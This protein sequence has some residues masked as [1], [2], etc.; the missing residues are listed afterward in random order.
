MQNRKFDHRAGTG[1]IRLCHQTAL[2]KV[3]DRPNC[4]GDHDLA[5]YLAA[6]LPDICHAL[7][8]T[9]D[10][11]T[12]VESTHTCPLFLSLGSCPYGF[13]CRFGESHIRKVEDGQG[14]L[15]SGWEL[16]VD[17]EK[18][19]RRETEVGEGKGKLSHMAEMNFISMQQIKEIRGGG[20][21]LVRRPRPIVL[22]DSY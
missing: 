15:G 16:V 9:P 1:E 5:A 10:D 8:T 3:C 6:R 4:R 21:T 7:P 22:R 13:K 2:G 19:K 20:R 14:A 18:V 12:P 11:L 17:E